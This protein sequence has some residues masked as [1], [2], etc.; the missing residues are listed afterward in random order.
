MGQ[1]CSRVQTVDGAKEKE[2]KPTKGGALSFN[3]VHTL[4]VGNLTWDK[5]VVH[6]TL[7]SPRSRHS[8]KRALPWF[9]GVPCASAVSV[10]RTSGRPSAARV[11][12]AATAAAHRS[13]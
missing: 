5:P 6:G 3:D 12:T 13:M 2:V 11:A 10:S 9:D 4:H 7:P 1:C 8:R